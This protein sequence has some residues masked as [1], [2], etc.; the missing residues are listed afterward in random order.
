MTPTHAK[1]TEAKRMDWLARSFAVLQILL[2]A[3]FVVA[4]ETGD[5]HVGIYRMSDNTTVDIAPSDGNTL[6]WRH[7]DGTTGAL[8][9]AGE[10]FWTSTYGW[11]GRPDGISA[12]FSGCADGRLTFDDL[13]GRRLESDVTETTFTSHG[14]TLRGRLVLPVGSAVVPIVVLVHGAERTSARDFYFL[15]L[16]LSAERVG[17]F[18]Y[19]KRGTGASAT[20]AEVRPFGSNP[21]Q[22]I[23]SASI[24]SSSASVSPSAS[25]TK[26][27]RKLKSRCARRVIHPQRSRAHSK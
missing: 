24:L 15:Q 7:F 1:P 2:F 19:D 13:E 16:M 25:S 18:V 22:R 23:A 26:T 17:A 21:L 11:T 5:C 10:G 27:S 4:A 6:R 3:P 8:T 12:R 9:R 14:V 20:R